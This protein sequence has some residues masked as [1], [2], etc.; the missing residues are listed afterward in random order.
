LVKAR[1]HA[2]ESG[3]PV[4]VVVLDAPSRIAMHYFDVGAPRDDKQSQSSGRSDRATGDD[5]DMPKHSNR[6]RGGTST[7]TRAAWWEESQ[8]GSSIHVASLD[9]SDPAGDA[10]DA[11]SRDDRDA[12][13]DV[14]ADANST[15]PVT[16]GSSPL[17]VAVFL[18]DGSILF[19]ATLLLMHDNGL[20]SRVTL[21]PWTGQPAIARGT[22]TD[23]RSSK[24][25]VD[26]PPDEKISESNPSPTPSPISGS[27]QGA[28]SAR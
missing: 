16:R 21:D 2:Q 6:G 23:E 7:G 4:E 10:L 13:S 9:T 3:K 28:G 20:H 5:G 27:G 19:A 17:R 25:L 18:P 8:L 24:A 22:T 15:G 12:V 14:E 11:K 26:C 1:V